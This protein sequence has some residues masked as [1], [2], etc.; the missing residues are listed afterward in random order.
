MGQ[1][2]RVTILLLDLGTRT[3]G[4]ANTEKRAAL[5]ATAEL[6]TAA[7][8][9]YIDFCLAHADKL[10]ERVSYYKEPA[11]KPRLLR[12]GMNG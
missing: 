4:G 10:S 2:S 9:F 8:A 6:L 12:A 3:K 5:E 7:R 1:A 11:R